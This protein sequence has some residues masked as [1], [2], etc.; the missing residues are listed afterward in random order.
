MHS[1]PTPQQSEPRS[2]P[3]W[4]HRGSGSERG[5]AA[6][7]IHQVRRRSPLPVR[8]LRVVA[9]RLPPAVRPRSPIYA[10]SASLASPHAPPC[11]IADGGW[12]VNLRAPGVENSTSRLWAT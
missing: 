9:W 3:V 4:L 1:A 6:R 11:A 10:S 7:R 5:C 12:R 8:S 2:L